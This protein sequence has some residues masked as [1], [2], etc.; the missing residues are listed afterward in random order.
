ME[1]CIRPPFGLIISLHIA[2]AGTRRSS[3]SEEMG[4]VANSVSER[5]VEHQAAI[6]RVKRSP[7]MTANWALAM[8]HSRGTIV[9]AFS[10]RFMTK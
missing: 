6:A 2:E 7:T 9:H 10:E 3:M 4:I 5:R 1:A 8:T